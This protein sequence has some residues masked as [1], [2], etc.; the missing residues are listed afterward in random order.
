MSGACVS[1]SPE[2]GSILRKLTEFFQGRSISAFL[3]GGYV[4][5]ALRGASTVDIDIAVQAD[6][7]SVAKDLADA[8]GGSL[9]RLARSDQTLTSEAR[10]RRVGRVILPAPDVQG[11]PRWVID[12]SGISGSIADDLMSRDFTVDAMALPLDCWLTSEWEV[13]LLDP[14]G[15]RQD[16]AE[17]IIRAIYPS[18]FR[19]D[20]ARLLRAVRLAAVL[21]FRIDDT[22]AQLISHEAH[23]ISSIAPERVRDEFLTI[24]SL[25]GAK[26]QLEKLDDLGLLCCIIP[27]LDMTKAVEQPREHYWDVFGHSMHAVEGVER[28]LSGCAED[29]VSRLVPWSGEMEE[30]FADD[31][32]DGHKRSTVLKLGAL[33]H[34]IAK[35]Q[36]KMVDAAGRTRFLGHHTLGAS[37]CDDLLHRLRLSSRGREMVCGMV[38]NHLRPMQMSHGD[39]MPTSRAVYRY[40]R[41]AGDVAI[42]TLYLSLADHLAARGPG[43][44]MG[45]W[46]RHVEI[47]G[48]ILQVGTQEQ[49]PERMPRLITGH[50]VI[51]EFGLTQGPI[52]GSLL[53]EVRDAQVAGELDS[54]EGALAWV[55]SWLESPNIEGPS[56]KS[57]EG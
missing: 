38:E 17:G 31:V 42:D 2:I 40:F 54:R 7:L 27:E 9:V 21:G 52:I 15:G 10:S 53:E 14:S 49:A 44:D 57:L 6:P 11:E 35:P 26:V 20:P 3:V 16:L 12:V 55:K 41:D 32:S 29:P 47:I 19:D 36:T 8:V 50:D 23:S 28:V 13:H 4:R 48:H 37:N 22:T 43:L 34:D 33:L 1:L 18:A 46:Q 5:D 24:L 30:R 56:L 25:E 51:Q 45:G 39:E